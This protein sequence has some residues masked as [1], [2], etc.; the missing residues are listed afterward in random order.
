MAELY[1]QSFCTTMDLLARNMGL[2]LSICQRGPHMASNVKAAQ[3][4]STNFSRIMEHVSDTYAQV[5][6]TSFPMP[7]PL[8]QVHHVPTNQE[9]H[10]EEEDDVIENAIKR[11]MQVG[12]DEE[13]EEVEEVEGAVP[14][15]LGR[16]SNSDSNSDSDDFDSQDSQ[17]EEDSSV[18]LD[19]MLPGQREN[20]LKTKSMAKGIQSATIYDQSEAAKADHAALGLGVTSKE[21]NLFMSK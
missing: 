6:E 19:D 3:K 4:I 8:G 2:A 15:R 18:D 9:Q 21:Q 12:D 7:F 13:V 20:Y 16:D 5:S 17:E 11:A 1:N 10:G 14:Y